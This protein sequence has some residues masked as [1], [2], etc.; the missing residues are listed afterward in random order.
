M[1]FFFCGY[2]MYTRS[3]CTC[4]HAQY[5]HV[6]TYVLL[7]TFTVFLEMDRAVLIL[8]SVWSL[9]ITGRVVCRKRATKYGQPLQG[10]IKKDYLNM[11]ACTG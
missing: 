5:V 3:V 7:Y 2:H 11:L 8:T 10:I 4:T 1:Q 9:S 6:F